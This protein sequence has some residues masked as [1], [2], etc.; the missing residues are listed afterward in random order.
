MVSTNPMDRS[1]IW[2]LSS[3]DPH[4]ASGSFFLSQ[5]KVS[6]FKSLEPQKVNITVHYIP[7][8]CGNWMAWT[9]SGLVCQLDTAGLIWEKEL[10]IEKMPP[11]DR[12]LTGQAFQ[13]SLISD[14]WERA[15]TILGFAIPRL[16]V[17]GSVRNQVKQVIE[18][19]SVSQPVG[20]NQE[21]GIWRGEIKGQETQVNRQVWILIQ[22]S[23]F[24]FSQ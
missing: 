19:Q 16:V 11:Q 8:Q 15:Q 2:E 17:P 5:K 3:T 10:S 1:G 7:T 18:S 21:P 22:L 20:T 4:F 13:A 12:A 23:N 9:V 24:I 6:A 14:W